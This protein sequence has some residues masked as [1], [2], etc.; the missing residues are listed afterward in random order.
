MT[1][2]TI[3]FSQHGWA[4]TNR[5]MHKLGQTLVGD[6]PIMELSAPNLGWWRTWLGF[7]PL[8]AQVEADAQNYPDAQWRIVGHSLG[9][10]IWLEILDRHPEWWERVHSLVLLAVAVGGATLGKMLDPLGALPLIARD[11]SRNRR[12]IATRIAQH[13]PTL[14]IAGDWDNG[15]DGTVEHS[16]TQ[17]LYAHWHCIPNVHHAQLRYHPQTIELIKTFWQTP[18]IAP[19][20]DTWQT[21]A[22]QYLY[23]LELFPAHYRDLRFARPIK[24]LPEGSTLWYWQNPIGLPHLFLTSSD[25]IIFSGFSGWGKINLETITSNLVQI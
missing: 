25:R 12:Q 10:L 24:A 4:D 14:A 7:E 3:L 20:P 17:L 23:S 9:G 18:T 1:M 8:L 21:K 15:S 5:V 13:I 2:R 22:L 6:D 11:L 19:P 16:A